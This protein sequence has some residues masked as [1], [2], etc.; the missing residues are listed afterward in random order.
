MKTSTTVCRAAAAGWLCLAIAAGAPLAYDATLLLEDAVTRAGSFDRAGPASVVDPV[1]LTG[2]EVVDDDAVAE[3]RRR[4]LSP[5]HPV[6]RGSSQNPDVYFQA[7][8]SATPYYTATPGI[9][10]EVMDRFAQKIIDWRM[11]AP[12][13]TDAETRRA[14]HHSRT[15]R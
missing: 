3:H 4:A 2:M 7:R 6:L 15:R 11:T 12:A 5:E 14:G 13:I 1:D 10:Q 8:E 9:V